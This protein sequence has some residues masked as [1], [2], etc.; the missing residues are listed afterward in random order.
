MPHIEQNVIYGMYSGLALLMD[1]HHPDEPNG[2]GVVH[3]SGSGWAAPLSLDATP[4]KESAH[5]GLEA[6]PLVDAGYTIFTVNHRLDGIENFLIAST[7]AKVPRHSDNNLFM[8]G[9]GVFIEQTFCRH[10]DTR[11]AYTALNALLFENG[12]LNRVKLAV[13]LQP[14]DGDDL[15]AF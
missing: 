2:I 1:I 6:S 10:N 15:F 7:A 11:R 3:A 5:V 8:V 9:F 14:F 4:L 13:L 12:L